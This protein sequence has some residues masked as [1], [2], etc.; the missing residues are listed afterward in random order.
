MAIVPVAK[1]QSDSA[2][3]IHK[4]R[5]DDIICPIAAEGTVVRRHLRKYLAS[6]S[7]P[8]DFESSNEGVGQ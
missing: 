4:P 3:I 6:L 7:L 2:D 5:L 8:S 1:I